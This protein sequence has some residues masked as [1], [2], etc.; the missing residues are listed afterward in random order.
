MQCFFHRDI[1]SSDDD[2]NLIPEYRQSAIADSAG[3]NAFL[4]VLFLS[5]QSETFCYR[6]GRY[7][8]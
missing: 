1:A 7:D 4:P 8:D 2:D 3:R 6:S 5:R